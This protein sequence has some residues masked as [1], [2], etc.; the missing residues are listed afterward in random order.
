MQFQQHLHIRFT[1]RG[2][3]F[4]FTSLILSYYYISD[5]TQCLEWRHE[6]FIYRN[7]CIV[8]NHRGFFTSG[9]LSQPLVLVLSTWPF[10]F[11]RVF[12]AAQSHGFVL[13]ISLQGRFPCEP[14]LH[15]LCSIRKLKYVVLSCQLL[16]LSCILDIFFYI[17]CKT[18]KYHYNS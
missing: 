1:L 2:F 17:Y 9:F 11:K 18:T 6:V 5:T 15:L 13:Q 10:P 12:L 14:H 3:P 7:F 8:L 16:W 4:C